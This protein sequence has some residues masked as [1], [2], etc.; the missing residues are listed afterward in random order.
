MKDLSPEYMT[1]LQDSLLWPLNLFYVRDQR[2]L[3]SV[4][5]LSEPELPEPYRQLLAHSDNMTSTLEGYH[6][7]ELHITTLNAF[8]DSSDTIRE[9]VLCAKDEHKVVEY[10][11][12]RIFLDNLPSDACERVNNSDI[13]LG[14]I[15]TQ[16]HCKHRVEPVG[17][18]SI[19]PTDFF[20]KVFG[21]ASTVPLFGR[22]NK[23]IGLDGAPI[24]EVC[25]VLPT[26]N[27]EV[28]SR[29]SS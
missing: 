27:G 23:L 13:P 2:P 24:A 11:A 29:E 26:F 20:T 1:D 17:F 5:A 28:P 22:Q 21:T 19:Q 3:P 15:L 14:T 9:V 18:F 8:N 6:N 10:G 12:S 7:C 16:C 25:E 4:A